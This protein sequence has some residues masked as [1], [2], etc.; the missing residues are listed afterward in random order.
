MEEESGTPTQLPMG[1]DAEDLAYKLQRTLQ[2]LEALKAMQQ[3]Q[4]QQH[5]TPHSYTSAPLSPKNS[6]TPP[7]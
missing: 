2:E 3:Q 1:V 7:P 6:S 4:Q 5:Q